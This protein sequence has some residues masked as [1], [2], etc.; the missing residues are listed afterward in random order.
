MSFIRAAAKTAASSISSIAKTKAENLSFKALGGQPRPV[1]V[2]TCDVSLP[3]AQ[4]FN[5]PANSGLR[6][7]TGRVALEAALPESFS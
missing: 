4:S 1:N 3:N 6:G 7:V 2:G 5:A